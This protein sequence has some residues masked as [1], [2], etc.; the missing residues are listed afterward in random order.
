METDLNIINKTKLQPWSKTEKPADAE[1]YQNNNIGTETFTLS[2]VEFSRLQRHRKWF[3]YF[4]G[5]FV[6]SYNGP[7]IPR[8]RKLGDVLKTDNVI[9]RT[10]SRY[11]A[12]VVGKSAEIEL[13]DEA[14]DEIVETW[15]K[16]IGF[17]NKMI[18][19]AR[20]QSLFGGAVV[21]LVF[22]WPD[23]WKTKNGEIIVT[24]RTPE[25]ILQ[26][27]DIAVFGMN[28]AAV[29]YDENNKIESLIILSADN[30]EVYTDDY[31]SR[32][33]SKEYYNL[34]ASFNTFSP[35]YSAT[36]DD[37]FVVGMGSHNL[38]Y[39]KENPLDKPFAFFLPNVQIGTR[40]ISDVENIIPLQESLNNALTTYNENITYHG[41]PT[42]FVKGVQQPLDANGNPQPF[43]FGAGQVL[44]SDSREVDFGRIEMGDLSG[45]KEAI[46]ALYN[47]IA[48]A[49]Y[50]LSVFSG[51]V[52]S[53]TALSYMTTDFNSKVAEKAEKVTNFIETIHTSVFALL[54]F[55]LSSDYSS[56]PFKVY[57]EGH[58]PLLDATKK[59][60]AVQLYS[61]G[62]LSKESL[63]DAFSGVE[64]SVKELE[65][66]QQEQA[67][68]PVPFT[69]AD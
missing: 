44:H 9:E 1:P 60:D 49:T 27:V 34:G 21:K 39:V 7:E 46:E 36:I 11:A 52:P 55:M 24:G 28:R 51:T 67:G 47:K 69:E 32:Y 2:Y 53:G 17:Q 62:V 10:V 6:T 43:I 5:D 23:S 42:F 50:S 4:V 56:I 22:S 31:I 18:E 65:R 61:L 48:E 8:N 13:E 38:E 16:R 59:A 26:Y 54:D 15:H 40:I 64:N 20:Y 12:S 35:S 3:Q 14:F 58:N 45:G 25:D 30:L 19:A 33:E 37:N 57:V 63:L 29:R 68:Q 66:I 41:F